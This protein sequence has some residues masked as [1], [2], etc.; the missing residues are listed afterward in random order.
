MKT[1]FRRLENLVIEINSLPDIYVKEADAQISPTT[2]YFYSLMDGKS[3][4]VNFL[5]SILLL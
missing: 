1:E 3:S 5:E 4:Q 2:G